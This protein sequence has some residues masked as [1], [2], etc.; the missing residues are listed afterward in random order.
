MYFT[1]TNCNSVL[2]EPNFINKRTTNL[3]I[4]QIV[5]E[6]TYKICDITEC[7][8]LKCNSSYLYVDSV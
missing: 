4:E 6:T 1:G 7:R 8:S 5:R 3:F 2:L